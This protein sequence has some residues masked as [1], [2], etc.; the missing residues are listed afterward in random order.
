MGELVRVEFTPAPPPVV[1]LRDCPFCDAPDGELVCLDISEGRRAWL[2]QCQNCAA[3]G[4]SAAASFLPR[5][6]DELREEARELW[7]MREGKIEETM[8]DNPHNPISNARAS[9]RELTKKIH[10][11]TRDELGQAP[12]TITKTARRLQDFVGVVDGALAGIEEEL[13]KLK[14]HRGT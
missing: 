2:V 7:N 8:A 12:G 14:G 11:L 6:D 4:P 13:Q 3:E 9:L 1:A 10:P 5:T